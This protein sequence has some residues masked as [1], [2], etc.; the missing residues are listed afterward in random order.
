MERLL[1]EEEVIQLLGLQNRP[2]PR[3][4]L[5]WLIRMKRLHPVR[6]GRGINSFKAEDIGR[7]IDGSSEAA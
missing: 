1:T 7:F 5:L 2:N 6:L 4:A 3:G